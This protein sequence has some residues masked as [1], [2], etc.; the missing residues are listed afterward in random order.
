MRIISDKTRFSLHFIITKSFFTISEVRQLLENDKNQSLIISC[1]C[2][3]DEFI[4]KIMILSFDDNDDPDPIQKITSD[5]IFGKCGGTE[6]ISEFLLS[7]FITD[8]EDEEY[9]GK[10]WVD[11][12]GNEACIDST[13]Y[14]VIDG[15]ST[16]FKPPS[17]WDDIN[18]FT[19][20][21]I[22]YK[23]KFVN[24]LTLSPDFRN[25][26]PQRTYSS[27][28]EYGYD[29]EPR[30]NTRFQ[31]N[32]NQD[33]LKKWA[34]KYD[35]PNFIFEILNKDQKIALSERLSSHIEWN[36]V[37]IL[38]SILN[39]EF[40]F[41][42]AVTDQKVSRNK[43]GSDLYSSLG[44]DGEED[45]YLSDGVSIRPDGSLTDD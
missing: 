6:L 33:N 20:K 40:K 2:D 21:N 10:N 16:E 30:G 5:G 27:L 43:G 1:R 15:F 11:E 32:I 4:K 45:I 29:M 18:E 38:K 9:S 22:S 41:E 3:D 17:I 25:L 31:H 28:D 24:N 8:I 12:N 19:F 7:N 39:Q 34:I 14:L 42:E 23:K 13:G 37:F 26:I 44:G 36:W 35:I